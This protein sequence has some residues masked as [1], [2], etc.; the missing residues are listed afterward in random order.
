MPK[1]NPATKAAIKKYSYQRARNSG[2]ASDS[3][4]TTNGQTRTSRKGHARLEVADLVK[5]QATPHLLN[6]FACRQGAGS[7]TKAHFSPSTQSFERTYSSALNALLP[8]A[9]LSSI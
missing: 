9:L 2:T 5:P 7:A 1:S 3:R 8:G 6:P 4:K